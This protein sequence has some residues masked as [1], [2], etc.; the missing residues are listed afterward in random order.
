MSKMLKNSSVKG[1]LH[2]LRGGEVWSAANPSPAPMLYRAPPPFGQAQVQ[3]H[4]HPALSQAQLQYHA[5]PPS[6]Q[7]QVQ[8]SALPP[9]GQSQVHTPSQA[10]HAHPLLQNL[11]GAGGVS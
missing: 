11:P 9:P 8:Y 6:G 4:A 10:H 7:V 5:P 1:I 2:A 3:Y